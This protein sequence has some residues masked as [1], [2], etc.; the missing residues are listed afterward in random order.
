MTLQNNKGP[1]HSNGLNSNTTLGA[2]LLK[3]KISTSFLPQSASSANSSTTLLTNPT[4][5]VTLTNANQA[6][7]A[8]FNEADDENM[9]NVAQL[10]RYSLTSGSSPALTAIDS[11]GEESPEANVSDSNELTSLFRTL[12]SGNAGSYQTEEISHENTYNVF[13]RDQVPLTREFLL[14]RVAFD[15]Q[16]DSSAFHKKIKH[17]FVLSTAGKPI[18]SLNGSDD[19]IMGYMGLITT[20]VSTF[21]EGLKSELRY[22]SR[23][24]F[25]IS[26]LSKS[27]LLLVAVTKLSRELNPRFGT[28]NAPPVIETQL[29]MI[30]NYILGVLS[31][32]AISKNFDKRMNYDL[33]NIL[34]HQD[35]KIL[36]SICMK[37]T[38]G[39]N[40]HVSGE[41]EIDNSFYLETLL[42]N[43][44]QCAIVKKA[45]RDKLNSIMLS[46]KRLK[47]KQHSS[48]GSL[49]ILDKILGSDKERD[50]SCD[51]L[52]GFIT[53]DKKILSYLRP[54][55]HRLENEDIRTLLATVSEL[56]LSQEANDSPE[57]WVPFCMPHF[58]DSG[59]LYIF[60]KQIYLP[61]LAMPLIITLLSGNKNSFYDMK[62][63][64]NYIIYKIKKSESFSR[65]LSAELA[66]MSTTMPVL[67][68]LGIS[69][70]RH[71]IYK[72]KGYNQLYMDNL[73]YDDG[74]ENSIRTLSHVNHLYASLRS[75]R[76]TVMTQAIAN[77]KRLTYTRW[78]LENV[79][80][81]AF[82]LED[83]KS[84][85]YCICGGTEMALLIIKESL[86]V[87]KWCEK[88]KRRLFVAEGTTF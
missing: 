79:W 17:F 16:G 87:I 82:L 3:P 83:E 77:P 44:I 68:D 1:H 46:T 63:V 69:S 8:V 85:F 49:I 73:Q 59:F 74:M 81:T 13:S 32:L 7:I 12:I 4:T 55:S 43:A 9:L 10:N 48:N 51:L 38:Y 36:D 31:K 80:I 21:Q 14:E 56:V 64:A 26:V 40:L 47:V 34:S 53:F 18:Y 78:K 39:F 60:V 54:K 75:S 84:E 35:F 71:F 20:I 86:R 65:A 11:S 88:Y 58:N 37:L 67:K 66:H 42:N 62:E 27:P 41:Y 50:I 70:I 76:A 6:D 5:A 61:G 24:N 22:I 29:S 33:R 45:T 15:K 19:L 30:Y 72:H 52:F 2:R 57:L 23:D 28:V 25:S